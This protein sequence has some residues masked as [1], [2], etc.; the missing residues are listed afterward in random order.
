MPSKLLATPILGNSVQR[1]LIAIAATLAAMIVARVVVSVLTHQLHRLSK[2]TRTKLDDVA[3]NIVAGTRWA[4]LAVGASWLGVTLLTLPAQA[5]ALVRGSATIAL[6]FQTGI[7]VQRLTLG[8]IALRGDDEE[9]EPDPG[10]ETT[11]TALSFV[12]RLIIWG[13]VV[14]LILSNLG[15]EVTALVAGLGIGGVAAALA[16]QN[17]LGDIIASLSIYLDR[18]FDIGDFVVV[19]DFMGTVELVR[20]RTTRLQS[21][22]GEEIIFANA[23]LAKSRVRNFRRMDER[24][25]SFEIGIEYN[26]SL[27]KVK[28]A[29][30][31]IREAIESMD[32]V[33]FDRAHFKRYG[34]FAL[35]YEAV[36]FV[37]SPDYALFMDI[38]QAINFGIYERFEEAGIPF[39]FPTQTIQLRQDGAWKTTSAAS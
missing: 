17:V 8:L 37:L 2:K 12:A 9:G 22:S 6:L 38:Q 5:V 11:E 27:D 35:I 23:D 24:R 10:K 7:W 36:Y 16:V 28:A 33:R 29:K 25:V 14:I 30:D 1:W 34:D 31:L 13:M 39:A 4:L 20:W 19:G 18:P 3:S 32:D 21:L 26:L 15:V